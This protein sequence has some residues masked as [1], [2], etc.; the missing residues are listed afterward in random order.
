[1]NY[2]FL[3]SLFIL[4]CNQKKDGTVLSKPEI[5][6]ILDEEVD[7][8]RLIADVNN[9]RNATKALLNLDLVKQMGLDEIYLHE[10]PLAI[11]FQDQS[12]NL[13]TFEALN[14]EKTGIDNYLLSLENETP[15]NLKEF[16]LD[17]STIKYLE[18]T[19]GQNKN[20]SAI[21][22]CNYSGRTLKMTLF[23]KDNDNDLLSKYSSLVICTN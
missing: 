11:N 5:D 23:C 9:S 10:E 8:E 2:F 13:V 19:S 20:I 16:I 18:K 3:I 15:N 14:I 17:G 7:D 21:I 1:M 4:S 22:H 12:K 6:I